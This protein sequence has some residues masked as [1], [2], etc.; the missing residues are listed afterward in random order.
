ML[1]IEN[2]NCE[3]I[4]PHNAGMFGTEKPL[5]TGKYIREC[6]LNHS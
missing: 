3:G 4:N 6:T 2:E 1:N 5:D